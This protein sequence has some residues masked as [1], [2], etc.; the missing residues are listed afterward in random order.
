MGK[1]L[2]KSQA[3][4]TFRETRLVKSH[5]VITRPSRGRGQGQADMDGRRGIVIVL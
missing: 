5:D 4:E 3:H 2:E 1:W